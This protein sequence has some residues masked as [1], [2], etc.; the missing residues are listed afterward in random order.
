EF[1]YRHSLLQDAPMIVT[2]ARFHFERGAPQEIRDKLH[3][4]REKRRAAQ[5]ETSQCAGSIFR[6]PPGG[7]A[8]RLLESLGAKGMR[9]GGAEVSEKHANFI[10]NAG[11]VG[12]SDVKMLI[13]QLQ[14]LA[15]ERAGINL[16]PEV[17]FIGDWE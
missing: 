12:A 3:E 5:P 8:G 13:V 6:N 17:L 14:E 1:S 4:Y 7:S 10:I 9:V 16:H 15:M 2:A 11:G